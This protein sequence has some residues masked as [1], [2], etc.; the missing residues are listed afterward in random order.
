MARLIDTL[1]NLDN[2]VRRKF[3]KVFSQLS[4]EHVVRTPLQEG[5]KIAD[6]LIEGPN[7]SWLLIG[8]HHSLPDKDTLKKYLSLCLILKTQFKTAVTYLAVVKESDAP[9]DKTVENMPGL[10]FVQRDGFYREGVKLI[11]ENLKGIPEPAHE[12][13]KKTV[14]PETRINAE[15]TTR[16]ETIIRDNSARLKTYFLD[17]DQEMAAKL[18]MVSEPDQ[19]EYAEN[20]NHHVRLI[21]GVAGSGKTLILINRAIM[22]CKKHPDKKT[23][24]LIHNK[25]ITADIEYKFEHY[26]NG[27]PSNLHIKTFHAFALAQKANVS[28]SVKPLFSAKDVKQ[29]KQTVLDKDNSPRDE[30]SISDDQLWS[31]LEY[32]NDYLIEDKTMY[33]N[34]ERQGRG[35]SLQKKQR[36]AIWTL[37]EQAMSLMSARKGYLPSLYI[38]ELCF[39]EKA[40]DRLSKYD[41][42]LLDE[43]QFFSPSWLRLVLRSLTEQ[44]QLFMC[45]DPNQGF[46]KSRLSWKS[47]GLNVR[48]RTKKLRHS[49]RTSYDVL[50]AANALLEQLDG[51][52]EDFIQ[53][54]LEIMEKGEK[55]KIVYSDASQDELQRF[56]NELKLVVTDNQFPLS[57]VMVLCSESY[58]AWTLKRS[59]EKELGENT[60]VNCNDRKD[61]S[62][63]LGKKIKLMSINSCTG[64]EAG[65]TFVL[66]V[67]EILNAENNLDL[68]DEEKEIQRQSSIRKLY[69]AM[70]RAG[71]KLV[72]FSTEK[73]PEKIEPF[74]DVG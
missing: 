15:C 71:Q 68:N 6:L 31:E 40:T 21:N 7:H 64:M 14:F 5:D 69:V 67:G 50:V 30:L 49:Y 18:D 23:L 34:Y 3:K 72:M 42:V 54:D 11:N 55:P 60:V 25:P 19:E 20:D 53:P 17:Y 66:G 13:I 57:Q 35:F 59:I 10:V 73:M 44:G 29:F 65:I 41:H 43:A 47:V 74:L 2:A 1:A 52:P 4:D 38:W 46:L 26:L 56:L 51:D 12:W 24:L 61:L 33:L 9:S 22:Y 8:C 37:Y 48:G 16:R 70:T 45:A 58:S 63:N 62:N 32:I 36:K 39:D 27:I 28:G